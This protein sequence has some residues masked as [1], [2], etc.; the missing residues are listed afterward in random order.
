MMTYAAWNEKLIDHVF[1]RRADSSPVTRIPATPEELCL[2]RGHS[3][4]AVANM[5]RQELEAVVEEFI[6][7]LK[8]E[9]AD[10]KY[11][12]LRYCLHYRED[13]S[14]WTPAGDQQPYFFAMLWFTCL[15]AYGYPSDSERD[16]HARIRAA[17]GS[18]ISLQDNALGGL[19]DVWEDLAQWTR[20]HSG[21]RELILPARCTWRTN[22]GRSHFL[23]FPNRIDREKLGTI[24]RAAGLIGEPPVRLVL[25]ALLAARARFSREFRDDLDALLNVY[26][27]QGQDPK[28]SPFWRAI[29]QEARDLSASVTSSLAPTGSVTILAEWDE[30]DLLMPFVA[31]DEDWVA[32]A[33]WEVVALEFRI[34]PFTRCTNLRPAVVAEI[35]SNPTL[36]LRGSEARAIEEGVVPLLEESSGLYRMAL[37]EQIAS[38]DMALV[39]ERQ[40]S[41]MRTAFGGREEESGVPGW[42]LLAGARLEQRD[43]LAGVLSGVTTLLQTTDAPPPT[44]IG[45]IRVL[46]NTFYALPHYLPMINAR[47]AARVVVSSDSDD[48][49]C[50]RSAEDTDLWHLP[51]RWLDGLDR[52]RDVEVRAAYE[53]EFCGQRVTR[54]ARARFR[55]QR[56]VLA[57]EYKGV[58]SGSFQV[59]TCSSDGET[60]V[61]PRPSL[62]LGFTR[63]SCDQSLDVLPL[64]GSARWLGPG[65][66]EM[67]LV[68]REEF[69]WLVVGP[70][71][72]PEFLVLKSSDPSSASTPSD[73]LSPNKGD[74]RHWL[75]AL[76]NAERIVWKLGETYAAG[77]DWSEPARELLSAYRA[78]G[79]R[80]DGTSQVPETR[81]DTHLRDVPWGVVA[82]ESG[83][84]SVHD[85]LAALFQNRAGV[86][87]RQVHEHIGRVLDLGSAHVLREHLVRAL[88]ESGALASLRRC[89]GRQRVVVA[90]RPVLVAHRRGPDWVAVLL[91]L[92]PSVV[93]QEFKAAAVRLSG[94]V[95]DERRSSNVELPGMLSVTVRD[96]DLLVRLSIELGLAPPEYLAWPDVD[97]LP[98]SFQVRGDLRDDAV[99]DVYVS[100][101][102]WCWESRSFRRDARR[103]DGVRVERRRDGRRVPIY[104]VWQHADVLGWSYSRT[105]ALLRAYERTGRPF[106]KAED[107]G[108]FVVAGDSPLHLPVPLGRLCA[109]VGLGAPGPRV[110]RGDRTSVEGYCYPFG[111]QLRRLLLPLLPQAWI[112]S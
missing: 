9:L 103:D 48:E 12:L 74:R 8:T 52:D 2:A 56:P 73:G 91:G 43:T 58:P 24:L 106:L 94:L 80:N 62:S 39:R 41:A 26:L 17:F 11:G 65:L 99:P 34:G 108:V 85:V 27:A 88:E 102:T 15:I 100:D 112:A 22:V 13:G 81:L 46:G 49:F 33:D 87:L 32:P 21:Q 76:T 31:F 98:A 93:R 84:D 78:R 1:R 63:A 3:P 95:L 5:S 10:E 86:P 105:W 101:A 110:A 82:N 47:S 83:R 97:Q 30:D 77:E 28:N 44:M 18:A 107:G 54:E 109:V 71:K 19:D 69:P 38:C 59:E 6:A 92:V 79:R 14:W 68:P 60:V 40:A 66:G 96:R 57:T 64:D 36:H 70:K 29:R 61:G 42:I 51:K 104:V 23:A 20:E 111:P 16:F 35:L 55:L 4:A 25:E 72:H 67:S 75:H 53:V 7:C 50:T 45:G 37:A 90:R 89:D